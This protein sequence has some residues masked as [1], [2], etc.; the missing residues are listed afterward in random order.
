SRRVS[1]N[2]F[3]KIL[4]V[5][6]LV[7]SA[8][9]M[10]SQMVLYSKRTEWKQEYQQT[11]QELQQK[12]KAL[13]QAQ[14]NLE[15]KTQQFQND[16]SNLQSKV[17]SLKNQVESQSETISSLKAD[18]SELQDDMRKAM[19][20]V[21]TLTAMVD[22]KESTIASLEQENTELQD[23]VEA[24]VS[25]INELD[26][27]LRSREEEIASL[28]EDLNQLEEN[29]ASVDEKRNKYARMLSRLSERGIRIP[30][31]DVKAVDGEV[32]KYE[33]KSDL[34]IINK[35]KDSGVEV[36]YPF[37][38]YRNGNYVAR[39]VVYRV[40]QKVSVARVQEDM[41][42]EGKEIREGDQATT[43]LVGTISPMS[44]SQR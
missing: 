4:A 12:T 33:K 7:L 32:I 25:Q 26:S 9:F 35:G 27:K 34:V 17:Q 44:I 39:A 8:G 1:M 29:Y 23:T 37:T 30:A 15:E 11:A 22:K 31:E 2:T 24:K 21:D 18:N 3:G 13:E 28:N 43:R 14:A 5:A 42:A 20:D 41:A 10:V 38:I 36:N 16:R 40:D 6:V 19:E